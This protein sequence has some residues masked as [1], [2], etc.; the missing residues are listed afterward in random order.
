MKKIELKL[1]RVG[2]RQHYTIGHLYVNGVYQCDTLEPTWR[3]YAHG[4]EKVKGESA[5]PEGTYQIW[6]R[7]NGKFGFTVPQLIDVPMFK[8]V[9]IHPGN[10]FTDTQG[11]ILVG[12]NSHVGKVVRSMSAFSKLM[13]KLFDAQFQGMGFEISIVQ[14]YQKGQIL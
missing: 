6:L 9:Q 13:Q 4:E 12:T 1:E 2:Y 7:S 5:I 3:D 10:T 8:G 14:K 11:C